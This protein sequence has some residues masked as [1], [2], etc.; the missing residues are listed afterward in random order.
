MTA[1]VF[2]YNESLET[3]AAT[4]EASDM[5]LSEMEQQLAEL[6]NQL[7]CAQAKQAAD[8]VALQ[9]Q[10]TALLTKLQKNERQWALEQAELKQELRAAKAKKLAPE[11]GTQAAALMIQH[12]ETQAE[13]IKQHESGRIQQQRALQ[14]RITARKGRRGVQ[15]TE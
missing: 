5:Q 10:R 6:Q 14:E 15:P 9:L 1:E 4:R 11:P 13:L 7:S 8:K 2:D 12:E 3:Q